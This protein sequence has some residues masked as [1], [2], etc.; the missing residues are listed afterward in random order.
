MRIMKGFV[1]IKFRKLL[2]NFSETFP[3]RRLNRG[4]LVQLLIDK[5]L[6][7][8]KLFRKPRERRVISKTAQIVKLQSDKL[9]SLHHKV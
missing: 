8:I 7:L 5:Y 4:R 1:E 9:F 3:R 2:P 6:T